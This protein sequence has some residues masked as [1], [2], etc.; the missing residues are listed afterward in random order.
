[1]KAAT[2]AHYQ[3]TLNGEVIFWEPS[4]RDFMAFSIASRKTRKVQDYKIPSYQDVQEGV[5]LSSDRKK[6]ESGV[7]M[8][9]KWDYQT[10]D[11]K[12]A[13]LK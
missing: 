5:I 4:T 2:S 11:L 9:G 6:I 7:K 1:M 3:C 12:P 10:L 13:L 8:N